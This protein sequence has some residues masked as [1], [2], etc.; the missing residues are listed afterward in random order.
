MS[1]RNFNKRALLSLLVLGIV[2]FLIFL[3]L[4]FA[5][6]TSTPFFPNTPPDS[7]KQ[8][9]EGVYH[10]PGGAEIIYDPEYFTEEEVK[11]LYEEGNKLHNFYEE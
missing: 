10:T 11:K 2:L 6:I 1:K 9:E 4:V 5:T 8:G 7:Q 3:Y